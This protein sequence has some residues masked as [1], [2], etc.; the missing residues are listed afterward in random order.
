LEESSRFLSSSIHLLSAGKY[1][2]E[3]KFG[4]STAKYTKFGQK[5]DKNAAKMAKIDL[6]K[7]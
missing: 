6:L 3:Y 1:I 2:K 4:H 5:T 7:S